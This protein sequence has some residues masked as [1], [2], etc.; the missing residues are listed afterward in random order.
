MS[1]TIDPAT[2]SAEL[3]ATPAVPV[4]PEA[5]IA[6]ITA[7]CERAAAGDLEARVTA[8]PRSSPLGPMSCALN[9]MLDLADAFVREAAAAM[10]H[11][12]RD[13][14]HRPI[15]LRG[16]K[17]AYRQSAVT[18]N[19]AGAKMKDSSEQLA[20]VGQLADEN[21]AAVGNVAAACEELHA[22]SAE[23][24]RQTGDSARLTE[25]TVREGREAVEVVQRLTA[26][27]RQVDEIVAVIKKV[28][29]QTNL[30]ALNA[31]IEAARAGEQGKGFAVVAS[32]V[33]E[34]SRNTAAATEEIRKEVDAMQKTVGAVEQ[35]IRTISRSLQSLDQTAASIAHSVEDQ[36]KA[37]NEISH[38]IADVSRN[39]SRVS[40]RMQRARR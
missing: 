6:H 17:G 9:A 31:T 13:Q 24:S 21:S 22:T 27:T 37:T 40:E 15:L 3:A 28:A 35:T 23:I 30:L 4:L 18:I 33:K 7:M 39:T 2:P 34:L 10:E 1:T 29:G 25:T 8:V 19:Q 14:F 36:V 26:A 16:L 20:L 32:E 11:S 5:E 12:S 38:S